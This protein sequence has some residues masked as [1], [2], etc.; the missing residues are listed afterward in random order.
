MGAFKEQSLGEG[1]AELCRGLLVLN[2]SCDIDIF[3]GIKNKIFL[4]VFQHFNISL[5]VKCLKESNIKSIMDD[6]S[7]YDL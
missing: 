6:F 4:Y 1:G 7:F 5:Y 2:E 3:T